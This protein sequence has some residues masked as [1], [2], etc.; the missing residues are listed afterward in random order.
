MREKLNLYSFLNSG[1]IMNNFPEENFYKKL[2][3]K[4]YVNR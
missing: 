4:N 3:Q 1:E 2:N